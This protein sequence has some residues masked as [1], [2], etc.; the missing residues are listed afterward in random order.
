MPW[1]VELAYVRAAGLDRMINDDY[2][3]DRSVVENGVFTILPPK[4]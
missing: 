3:N 4:E 2:A 1:V